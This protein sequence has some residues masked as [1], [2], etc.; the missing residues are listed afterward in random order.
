MREERV[1]HKEIEHQGA[2]L[3]LRSERHD[4]GIMEDAG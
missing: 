1:N 4:R 2:L 3:G